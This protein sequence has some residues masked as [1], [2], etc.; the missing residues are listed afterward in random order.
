MK[1]INNSYGS[2]ASYSHLSGEELIKQNSKKVITV[3][4]NCN[5][6]YKLPLHAVKQTERPASLRSSVNG[7]LM[8]RSFYPIH[9]CCFGFTIITVYTVFEDF[10]RNFFNV[11][12]KCTMPV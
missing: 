10:C 7:P 1:L 8:H 2:L 9:Y 12:E 3:P 6:S 4:P 11:L 5:S